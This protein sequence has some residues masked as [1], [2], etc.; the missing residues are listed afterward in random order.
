VV[1]RQLSPADP[2]EDIMPDEELQ[3]TTD[4][5]TELTDGTQGSQTNEVSVEGD[6]TPGDQEQAQPEPNEFEKL[7]PPNEL[8][9]ELKGHWKRMHGAYSKVLSSAK[10]IQEKAAVVDRF[11]QDQEFAKQTLVGWAA[12]NGYQLLPVGAQQQQAQQGAQQQAVKA[13][14]EFVEMAKA[15][16]PPEL[17]WMAEP[18]A[19]M[20]W[21]ATQKML[22]PL[23]QHQQTQSQ[24]QR[25]AEYDRLSEEL[26][27]TAPGWEAQ[28]QDMSALLDFF[29][30]PNM[31]HPRFGS[32]LTMLYNMVT[33]NGA[34]LAEAT[35]RVN[36]AVR[37]RP[38]SQRGGVRQ[39]VNISDQVLNAKSTDDAW[40]AAMKFAKSQ[41]QRSQ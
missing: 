3:G 15:N 5:T 37:N 2:K 9:E 14:S 1:Q 31:T 36:N 26:S 6:Q 25:S 33:G 20:M 17:Q 16:L 34:A 32:K 19:N 39:T 38:S 11:Y 30:S 23:V 4:E 29:S 35:K 28:E 21:A 10:S 41:V 27:N 18:N 12:Q 7:V 24:A 13:P 22:A 8:P 40:D